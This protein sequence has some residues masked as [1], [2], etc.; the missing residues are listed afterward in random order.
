MTCVLLPAC[1]TQL[2]S[3]RKVWNGCWFF[4]GCGWR[5]GE[6]TVL[7]TLDHLRR[8]TRWPTLQNHDLGLAGLSPACSL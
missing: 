2:F 7:A 5:S 1:G 4:F 6:A 3:F 8:A